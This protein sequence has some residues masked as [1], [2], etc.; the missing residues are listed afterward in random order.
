MLLAACAGGPGF[1]SERYGTLAT[2]A[3]A[4]T[5]FETWR[6]TP[7]LWGG[8]VIATRNL[9]RGSEIEVLS[10]PLRGNQQP[11][12]QSPSTGRFIVRSD[13]FVEPVDYAAGR[14][15]TVTGVVMETAS[16]E[17]GSATATFPVMH[18]DSI[19]LWPPDAGNTEPRVHFGFGFVIGG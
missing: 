4:V 11:D 6:D 5:E 2:P 16:G 12:V 8:V 15:V 10:Y 19:H 17:I 3:R 13:E 14:Q 9:E 7:V 1:D 18:A